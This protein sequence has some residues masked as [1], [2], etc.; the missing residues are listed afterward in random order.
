MA[1]FN[2]SSRKG[3]VS[4]DGYHVLVSNEHGKFKKQAYSPFLDFKA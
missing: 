4:Y 3:A 1:L 2:L